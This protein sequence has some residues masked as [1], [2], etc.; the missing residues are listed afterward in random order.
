[1]GDGPVWCWPIG[2]GLCDLA[3]VKSVIRLTPGNIQNSLADGSR[4][5]LSKLRSWSRSHSM[6]A[7]PCCTCLQTGRASSTQS[8]PW[9]TNRV[10]VDLNGIESRVDWK[11]RFQLSFKFLQ[12]QKILIFCPPPTYS[13]LNLSL[14]GIARRGWCF[15][16]N[17]LE[18]MATMKLMTERPL[19]SPCANGPIVWLQRAI[20]IRLVTAKGEDD[21]PFYYLKSP[22]T[23]NHPTEYD[24]SNNQ[25][26]ARGKR[27]KRKIYWRY[28]CS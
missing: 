3:V 18:E 15:F 23:P 10:A 1:M 16:K 21:I 12:I 14:G 9:D 13:D 24:N 22:E 27:I 8:T 25:K 19:V 2:V 20:T 26:R 7:C 11:S 28:L 17:K 6:A 5:T 4:E